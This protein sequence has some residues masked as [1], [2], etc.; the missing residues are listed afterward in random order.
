M[1]ITQLYRNRD[2]LPI[3]LVWV[4]LFYMNEKPV[5]SSSPIMR[6]F[7]YYSI[8]GICLLG[9]W[10][11]NC[12]N[13]YFLPLAEHKEVYLPKKPDPVLMKYFRF[14]NLASREIYHNEFSLASTY[15]DSAFAYKQHPFFVDVKNYILV[16]FK[17]CQFHKNEPYLKML[18][19][20]KHMDTADLFAALPRRVFNDDNLK[21]IYKIQMKYHVRKKSRSKL[22]QDIHDMFV[23]DQKV[24]DYQPYNMRDKEINKQVYHI[25]DSTDVENARRFIQICTES[26]FPSEEKTGIL[27]ENDMQWTNVID[28]L[29]W[30]FTLSDLIRDEITVLIEKEFVRG[31]IHPSIYASLCEIYNQ[32]A[33]SARPDFNF[34]NTTVVLVNDAAYRP[35]VYYSDS[36][37]KLVNTNR[38]SI[39]LDSFHISQKQVVCGS[40]FKAPEGLE[41]IQMANYPKLQDYPY[42]FAKMVFEH[43]K[44]DMSKYMINTEKILLEAQCEEK[45]Y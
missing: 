39:G 4:S 18:M 33:K 36:L 29:L 1:K 9:T 5:T 22:Q 14:T 43:E 7:V 10:I 27:Y 20:G 6:A 26:G 31:N 40:K 12:S 13:G 3:F 8:Y 11:V 45:C 44:Q 38:T 16:N 42:G 21:L 34:M 41:M 32:N 37:M 35:F 25:R 15:Y 17:S 24:R 2:T 23:M 30:H 28:F 19:V